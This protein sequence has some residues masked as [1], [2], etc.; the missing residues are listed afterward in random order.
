MAVEDTVEVL[1]GDR[2]VVHSFKQFLAA[3]T[4]REFERT[5]YSQG[6]APSEGM[7]YSM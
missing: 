7:E 5:F 2:E 4:R 1:G 3:K 6:V